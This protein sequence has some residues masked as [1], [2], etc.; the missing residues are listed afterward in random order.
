MKKSFY[1]LALTLAFG[2]TACETDVTDKV[3]TD[4]FDGAAALS[5]SGAITDVDTIGTYIDLRVSSPYLET[6]A[7][8]R[9][10]GATIRLFDGDS[11][12][13]LVPEV[14]P[15]RYE[16][17][18]FQSIWN[19]HYRIE[20]EVP[21][22]YQGIEGSWESTLDHCNPHLSLIAPL[23]PILEEDST[24]FDFRTGDSVYYAD[25][26]SAYY[27]PYIFY[28]DPAGKGNSYWVKSYATT[29][30]YAPNGLQGPFQPQET[31]I[32]PAN[33]I[34]LYNDE[35]SP[36]GPQIARYNFLGPPYTVYRDTLINIVFETRSVSEKLYDYLTIMST[37]VNNG[38]LFSVPYSPQIGNIRRSDDTTIFGLGY[39][40]ATSIRF[41]S[42]TM[43]HPF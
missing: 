41:D 17:L 26:D 8:T 19:H 14:S 36:E 38:G 2:F 7:D 22:S 42:I 34:N 23:F 10:E 18:A 30:I 16:E 15:G 31:E 4:A 39:F 24:Y 28:L 35:Q 1:Y 37:N 27:S 43:F 32:S 29:K 20:I 3:K 5:V 6:G 25:A 13:G 33:S 11:L 40:S 12:L 9:V 21:S